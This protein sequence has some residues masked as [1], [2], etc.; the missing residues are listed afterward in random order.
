MPEILISSPLGL[1]STG[2]IVLLQVFSFFI[3][4]FA[5][6]DFNKVINSRARFFNAMGLSLK[7]YN[8]GFKRFLLLFYVVIIVVV[9]IGFDL[10]FILRPHFL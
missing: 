3:L 10:L 9:T 4:F 5:A 6:Y 1:I 2:C 7:A 8:V